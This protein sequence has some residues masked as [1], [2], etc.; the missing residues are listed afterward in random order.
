MKGFPWAR[1]LFLH[2]S[3]GSCGFRIFSSTGV[4]VLMVSDLFHV[5]ACGFPWV[6]NSCVTGAR[7]PMGWEYFRAQA[8]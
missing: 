5:Q 4:R 7:V 8:H 6:R 1:N 2:A 3:A